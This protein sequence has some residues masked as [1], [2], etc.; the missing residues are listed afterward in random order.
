MAEE[1]IDLSALNG[2]HVFIERIILDPQ[3][4]DDNTQEEAPGIYLQ[5]ILRILHEEFSP[6]RLLVHL[7]FSSLDAAKTPFQEALKALGFQLP[8]ES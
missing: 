2:K 8:D 5:M 3:K 7:H 1:K 4:N 6:R